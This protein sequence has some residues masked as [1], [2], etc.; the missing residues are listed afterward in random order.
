MQ[1]A[2]GSN[3][4]A[5]TIAQAQTVNIFP[6]RG[7]NSFSFSGPA[8]RLDAVKECF[9]PSIAHSYLRTAA[10][11]RNRLVSSVDYLTRAKVAVPGRRNHMVGVVRSRREHPRFISRQARS[12]QFS[13][14]MP[15][16][17]GAYAGKAMRDLLK[18]PAGVLPSVVWRL[19]HRRSSFGKEE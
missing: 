17:R 4:G 16:V 18:G 15:V 10:A 19:D 11:L 3:P 5:P 1:G 14:L 2:P 8:H 13:I 7:V 12:H 6:V 9:I